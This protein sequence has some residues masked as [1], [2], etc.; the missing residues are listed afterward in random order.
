MEQWDLLDDKGILTGK[1]MTRGEKMKSGQY[2]LV[3]HIWVLDSSGRLLIQKRA[4]HLE[5]MPNIWA[6]TGGSAIAGEDSRTAAGR[7]LH[8]ELGIACKLHELEHVNRMNR[9]NSIL[10]IWLLRRDIPLT[11]LRLQVEEVA[12]AQWITAEEMMK[13]VHDN[14]FHNYGKDYFDTVFSYL[15]S[16]VTI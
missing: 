4:A 7:E 6:V 14:L 11:E 5:L 8:E 1:T 3:V 12:A 10:D 13:M 9:H 2:H 15:F 16:D